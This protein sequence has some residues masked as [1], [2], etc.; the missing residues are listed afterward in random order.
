M[1]NEL[2][3]TIQD[4]L[5]ALNVLPSLLDKSVREITGPSFPSLFWNIIQVL[6]QFNG[7]TPQTLPPPLARY[8][9]EWE[10]FKKGKLEHLDRRAIRCLC[11]D[12]EIINDPSFCDYLHSWKVDL[13]TR[14]IKG[15]VWSLHATWV[16]DTPN[17]PICQTTL[18]KILLYSGVDKIIKKWNSNIDLI[19]KNKSP[20]LFGKNILVNQSLTPKHAADIWAISE[21]SRFMLYAVYQATF[22]CL[23]SITNNEGL[24]THL[25]NT[26]LPWEGWK[27][28]PPHLKKIVTDLILYQENNTLVDRIRSFVLNHPSLGDPRLPKNE[29]NWIGI[30]NNARMKFISWLSK[31]D[32]VFF[33]D[34]VLK[35]KDLHGRREFWLRYINRIQ[36]SRPFLSK[37]TA[38]F[39]ENT[40]DVN[41][42]K[43]SSGLNQ[44]VFVLDFGRIVAVEF[45]DVG[46]IYLYKRIEFEARIP[47]LWN[48]ESNSEYS[49]KDRNLPDDRKIRH[50]RL[51]SIVHIDWREKTATILAREGIRA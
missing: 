44:A 4:A 42:G 37:T 23:K 47:R 17:T 2:H 48:D 19:L 36:S 21:H 3:L 10:Q 20:E 8:K 29:N 18:G 38:T 30:E 22:V 9:K 49:F 1:P 27:T 7:L 34:H 41:F 33:F 25:F 39:F 46:M 16:N 13:P 40:K 6:N 31:R 45:S 14:A 11:W 15:L 51:R 5:D 32:I 35:G 24:T 50:K 43:L 12:H 28:S 26:L